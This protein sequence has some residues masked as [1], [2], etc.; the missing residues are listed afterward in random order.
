MSKSQNANQTPAVENTNAEAAEKHSVIIRI[1]DNNGH[2]ELK[3]D[4]DKAVTSICELHFKNMKW[5][6]IQGKPFQF[7]AKSLEDAG[8]LLQDVTRL[9]T[10][11]NEAANPVVVMTPPLQGGVPFAI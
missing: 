1:P 9:R 4:V 5:P 11:L 8:T 10:I 3:Q 6:F 2:T 7:A